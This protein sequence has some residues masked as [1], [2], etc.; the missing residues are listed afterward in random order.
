L[1]GDYGYG[2]YGLTSYIKYFN[3]ELFVYVLRTPRT[4]YL[5]CC[6][7]TACVTELKKIGVTMR[8]IKVASCSRTCSDHLKKVILSL[9]YSSL[10]EL[11]AEDRAIVEQD[12]EKSLNA[13]EL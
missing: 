13:I 7:A 5:E 10:L 3:P 4:D 2:N 8:N 11:S 1:F 12:V 9:K 6:Y